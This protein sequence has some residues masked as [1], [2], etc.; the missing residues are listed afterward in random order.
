MK[1]TTSIEIDL[2][3]EKVVQ[4]IAGTDFRQGPN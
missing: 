4:L 3:R 2:P 1:F